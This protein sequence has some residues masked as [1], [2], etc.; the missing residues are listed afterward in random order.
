[1]PTTPFIAFLILLLQGFAYWNKGRSASLRR[2]AKC[3]WRCSGFS[4]FVLFSLFVPFCALGLGLGLAPL[5]LALTPSPLGLSSCPLPCPLLSTRWL[6]SL[7]STWTTNC[8]VNHERVHGSEMNHGLSTCSWV[9]TQPSVVD[10]KALHEPWIPT[11]VVV[12][13]V[14]ARQNTLELRHHTTEPT[15]GHGKVCRASA[16]R[17]PTQVKNHGGLHGPWS[18]TR[19]MVWLQD[20]PPRT[21]RHWP[22]TMTHMMGHGPFDSLLVAPWSALV[23]F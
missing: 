6:T 8:F 9:H 14:E 5:A 17:P 4:F 15:T 22:A 19:A 20:E 7:R 23:N 2:I 10:H 3:D 21:S 11:R 13:L 1:M 18:F 16:S 12:R